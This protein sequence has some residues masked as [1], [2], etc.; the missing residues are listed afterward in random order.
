[1]SDVLD[2]SESREIQEFLQK[3]MHRAVD[4]ADNVLLRVLLFLIPLTEDSS[5]L[6]MWLL[7]ARAWTAGQDRSQQSAHLVSESLEGKGEHDHPMI[8]YV[9][10]ATEMAELRGT[11]IDM[12]SWLPVSQLS[13][14]AAHMFV[15]LAQMLNKHLGK[16]SFGDLPDE[17]VAAQLRFCQNYP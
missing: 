6:R 14:K 2:F 9:Q 5:E 10:L 15:Q 12:Q 7:W 16:D 4:F 11:A 1:M 13:E 3:D 17:E 8:P